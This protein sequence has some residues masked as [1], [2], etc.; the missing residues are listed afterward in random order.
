MAGPEFGR[1]RFTTT[2]IFI[3]MRMKVLGI[4]EGKVRSFLEAPQGDDSG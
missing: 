4:A 2:R 1:T 3:P